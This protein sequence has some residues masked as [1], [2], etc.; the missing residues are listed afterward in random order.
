MVASQSTGQPSRGR[1]WWSLIDTSA[2]PGYSDNGRGERDVQ[3]A[4]HRDHGRR[5]GQL[6][7]RQ[8]P[9]VG[10]G[11]D[12]VELVAAAVD[13]GQHPQVEVRAHRGQ[14]LGVH[15]FPQRRLDEGLQPGRCLRATGG[16]QRDV[17]AAPRRGRRRARRSPAR[18]RRTR[19]A[20]RSR[21]TGRPGR[22]ASADLRRRERTQS[23]DRS[24]PRPRPGLGRRFAAHPCRRE[25]RRGRG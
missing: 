12:D 22:Y 25:D 17:V 7:E 15:P 10:V 16:E 3:P 2:A 23:L 8:R 13:V 9:H 14:L 19:S 6:D 4:V 5:V 1:R 24:S 18:C 21:T 20:G 11:V